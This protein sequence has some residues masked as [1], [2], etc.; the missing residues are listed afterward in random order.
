MKKFVHNLKRKSKNF[1]VSCHE[2]SNAVLRALLLVVLKTEVTIVESKPNI[3]TFFGCSKVYIYIYI[4]IYILSCVYTPLYNYL[5][6][7]FIFFFFLLFL[8]FIIFFI[9]IFLLFRSFFYRQ[10]CSFSLFF[11]P[12]PLP[13][14]CEFFF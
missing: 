7:I 4:Y 2:I 6:N 9:D 13:I 10:L 1:Q 8:F 11:L 5:N 12:P 3:L 14:C